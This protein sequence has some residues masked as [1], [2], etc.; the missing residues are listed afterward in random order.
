[1]DTLEIGTYTNGNERLV[2]T[3]DDNPNDPRTWDNAGVM[4][5]AHNRYNL[6]DNNT[7]LNIEQA[8]SW[9]ACEAWLKENAIVWLPLAL[10]DHGGITMSVGTGKDKWDSG[11]VG[12]IYAGRKEFDWAGL[13]PKK[14]IER[15]RN[16]LIAEVEE[17]DKYLRGEC[18]RWS[19][20]TRTE[21]HTCGKGEWEYIE[22]TGDYLGQPDKAS[23]EEYGIEFDWDSAKVTQ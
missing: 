11:Q 16:N 8:G 9:K 15:M 18:W 6:G 23:I 14:D 10:Y 4:A 22:G 20:E 19:Y 17:Y 12:Y 5:C 7:S 3:C 2:I 1:M 21:C 13:D